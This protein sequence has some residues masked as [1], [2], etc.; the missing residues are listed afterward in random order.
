MD[1]LNYFIGTEL[2]RQFHQFVG[3]EE[4]TNEEL[5]KLKSLSISTTTSIGEIAKLRNLEEL[6][7]VFFDP[8]EYEYDMVI[9]YSEL[10]KLVNLRSLV[11]A[12]NAHIKRLDLSELSNL[13]VLILVSNAN[14]EHIIGLENLKKLKRVVIVGNNVKD[15]P[16][17]QEYIKNTQCT[18][19]NILDYKI[20]NSIHKNPDVYSFLSNMSLSYDTNLT[21]AEKI[22]I[23]EIFTY[24]FN[25]I[26]KMNEMAEVILS[27]IIHQDMSDQEKILVVYRY[28]IDHL[29][30]D[31][32]R[33]EE[34]VHYVHQSN[35]I[36]TYDN[37]H[38]YINSSYEAF[39]RGRVVCEG[40]VNMINFLLNKLNIESRTVYCAVRDSKD[41]HPGYYNHSSNAIKIDDEWYYFDAQLE[42][43]SNELKYF[44]KTREEFSDTH[45]FS[46]SSQVLKPKQKIK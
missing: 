12:N 34:R 38:K 27:S 30:Y 9:D 7:I 20:F 31:H 5:L 11:I 33:L 1:N 23:G 26:N 44:K 2:M 39:V 29:T 32:E 21:F 46:P 3:Y 18:G 24:S 15:I 19:I 35:K 25:M 13:E 41:Y 28:V 37:N 16:N 36:P 43:N 40:Y 42:E 14:L 45:E 6:S 4:F 17:I 8:V 22:G 10:A